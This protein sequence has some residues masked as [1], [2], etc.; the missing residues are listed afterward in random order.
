M[1]SKNLVYAAAIAIA[2]SSSA[3]A[4]VFTYSSGDLVIAVRQV[5]GATTDVE[6]NLGPVSN[7]PTT[8]GTVVLRNTGS[9][10]G[11]ASPVSIRDTL[12]TV[13]GSSTPGNLSINAFASGAAASGNFWMARERT[14]LLSGSVGDEG[15]WIRQAKTVQ[16]N[17]VAAMNNVGNGAKTAAQFPGAITGTGYVQISSSTAQSYSD[18]TKTPPAGTFGNKW[19]QGSSETYNFDSGNASVA[20][21]INFDFFKVQFSSTPSASTYL[22]FFTL[23]NHANLYFTPAGAVVPEPQ[24]YA[25]IF[26]L[27]L[28][29]F[30]L[31]RRRTAK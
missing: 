12:Q 11:A 5:T 27:G 22:G 7:L 16:N 28:A 3:F 26:G 2:V 24:E 19:L 8:G 25:A 10:N 21:V 15:A 14:G 23:D 29:G 17:V 4:Q 30:A 31:W 18:I 20:K 9:L 1:N 6:F 13:Y